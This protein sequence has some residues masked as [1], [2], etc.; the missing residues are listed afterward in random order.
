MTTPK[1]YWFARRFPVGHPRKAMSPIHW[2]GY[3]AAAAFVLVLF[4]GGTAFAW[5]GASGYLVHGIVVFVIASL[6]GGGWFITVANAMGDQTRT[7]DDYR[8]DASRV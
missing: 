7:V 5:L 2:K 8:K 3:A 1:E 6:I 4:I